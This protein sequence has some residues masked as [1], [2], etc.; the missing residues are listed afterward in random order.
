MSI[1]YNSTEIGKKQFVLKAQEK[2]PFIGLHVEFTAF[3]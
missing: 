3:V 2:L 1:S